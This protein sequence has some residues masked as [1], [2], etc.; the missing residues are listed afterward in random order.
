MMPWGQSPVLGLF[1]ILHVGST[2]VRE[3]AKNWFGAAVVAGWVAGRVKE[4][5]GSIWKNQQNFLLR[6][7]EEK[8]VRP[9]HHKALG[10][11]ML[12]L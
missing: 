2:G 8:G 4:S 10:V 3:P 5:G 6:W 1:F 12:S 11:E 7:E 9:N